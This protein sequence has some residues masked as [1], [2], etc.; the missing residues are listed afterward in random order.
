[1]NKKI[2]IIG[3]NGLP[4]KYGGF[5]TLTNYLVTYL[6]ESYSIT[7]YCSNL[8]KGDKAKTYNGARLIH[9]PLSA[10]GFQGII[11]DVLSI[12]HALFTQDTLLILGSS[13][14]IILP[15]NFLFRKKIVFNFGGLDWQRAKWNLL[16][17]WF[18]K[19]SEYIGV[20]LSDYIIVDNPVFESYVKKE[21]GKDSYVIEYGSDHVLNIRDNISLRKYKL[22]GKDY[23]LSVSRAQEDNNIHVLLSAFKDL[24]DK[25]VVVISNWHVSAYGKA[26]KEKYTGFENILLIDAIYDQRELDII[27]T[28][29]YC[30]IHTHS[31]CGS[32][33]SLIEAMGLGLPIISFDV[34][35]NRATTENKAL[36]FKDESELTNIIQN[37]NPAVLKT[38]ADESN[39]IA[40]RRYNWLTI[41]QKYSEL[42]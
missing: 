12:I 34:P 5:E 40:Q 22:E 16:T 3:T 26:L 8:H 33:P 36:F 29:S 23:F 13:G 20:K 39:S 25:T 15:L 17:K 7:V 10:N 21:Y 32:A 24:S 31:A 37:L 38:L 28:A 35:A 41:S 2:A 9:L 18:L 27:R 11:Y 6:S 42:F 19:W 30:Y 14:T 1:M 4:A